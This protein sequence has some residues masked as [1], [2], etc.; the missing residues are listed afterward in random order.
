MGI[1]YAVEQLSSAV[2]TLAGSDQPLVERV[3][4][5]WDERIQNLWSSVYLT[6]ELNERFKAMWNRYTAPSSDPRSTVVR[7][8][9]PD[10]LARVATEIVGLALDTVAASA[11][12]ETAAPAP[13][14]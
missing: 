8:M 7:Q 4:R 5:V 2:E 6:S 11:R 3:Q 12:G 9:A 1:E 14:H 10:E 13:A